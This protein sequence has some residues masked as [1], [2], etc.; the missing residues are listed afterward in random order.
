[1][2]HPSNHDLLGGILAAQLGVPGWIIVGALF[3]P[4]FLILLLI[5]GA[6]IIAIGGVLLG[7]VAALGAAVAL[8]VGLCRVV[9][10]LALAA[11]FDASVRRRVSLKTWSILEPILPRIKQGALIAVF[12]G[13]LVVV[14]QLIDNSTPE[15]LRGFAIGTGWLA[16]VVGGLIALGWLLAQSVNWIERR[17]KAYPRRT[18][19]SVLGAACV[20]VTLFGF[21]CRSWTEHGFPV[22][23]LAVFIATLPI[24]I[25]LLGGF[26]AAKHQVDKVIPRQGELLP[27][28]VPQTPAQPGKP[29]EMEPDKLYIW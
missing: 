13:A 20:F 17:A 26:F 1:M 12:V 6:G 9:A 2:R 22:W 21:A 4:H 15:Q 14:G 3:V 11:G 8:F 10:W 5:F 29:R 7:I 24:G 23:A 16:T 28:V 25:I 19:F 27:P 18:F